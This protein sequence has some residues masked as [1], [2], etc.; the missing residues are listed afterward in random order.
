[1]E[2]ERNPAD[3]QDR[4]EQPTEEDPLEEFEELLPQSE[5]TEGSAPLP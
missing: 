3:D 4:E 5:P 2:Q 1:M